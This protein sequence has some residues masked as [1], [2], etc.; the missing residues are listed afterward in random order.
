MYDITNQKSFLNLKNY[1]L[2]II[3]S[4]NLNIPIMIIGNK[5]D[6]NKERKVSTWEGLQFSKENDF[7]FH[8]ISNKED[9][10][11]VI[12]NN[13]SK[14]I[15]DDIIKKKKGLVQEDN[16][17]RLKKLIEKNFVLKLFEIKFKK[18]FFDISYKFNN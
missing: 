4:Q 14:F 10:V 13:F 12:L 1:Y 15:V 3:N 18:K 9:D 16:F 7:L 8:E 5:K 11:N 2:K 17:R 6:L